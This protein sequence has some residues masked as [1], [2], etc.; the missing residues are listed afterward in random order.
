MADGQ[1]Q[2]VVEITTE[3]SNGVSAEVAQMMD[4]SMKGFVNQSVLPT[5]PQ[6]PISEPA[7]EVTTTTTQETVATNTETA[8]SFSFDIFKDKFGYDTPEAALTDI[9]QL[10]AFKA[11]PP[12]AEIKYENE[13]SKKLHLAL[14]NG[15]KDE[16]Y[17][18]LEEQQKLER[19]TTQE[20][21]R[22]SAAEIIK[23]GMQIKYKDLTPEEIN[24]KFNKQ[25]ALPKQPVQSIDELD[26]DFAERQN[27]WKEQVA[28]VE[29]NKIIDAKLARPDLEVAKSK[30]VLPELDTPTKDEAYE[31]WQKSLEEMEQLDVETKEAYKV[32]T[33]KDIQSKVKFVDAANKIDFEFQYEPDAETYKQALELVTDQ[34]K[35]YGSFKNSDGTPNRKGFLEFVYK[36]LYADKMISEAIKQGSN[37]RMKAM[38]PDNSQGGLVRQLET[39]NT[40]P[41]ELQKQMDMS[42]KPFSNAGGRR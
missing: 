26:E 6:H 42:L 36:G 3:T 40:E 24:Y 33:A 17:K 22:D 25:Y 4:L 32:F 1:E 35:F 30:I 10:R 29:M 5:T 18:I 12:K 11:A 20:I 39:T 21:T 27:A 2:T 8:P 31:Q 38:L 14:M 34:E 19:F 37:A 7:A 13:E 9:E 23:L 28:D 41:N 16:V 15:K